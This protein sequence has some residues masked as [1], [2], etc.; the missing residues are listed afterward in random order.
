MTRTTQPMRIN[1]LGIQTTDQPRSGAKSGN[2]RNEPPKIISTVIATSSEIN[3]EVDSEN[4]RRLGFLLCSR[5]SSSSAV[6]DYIRYNKVPLIVLDSNI[7]DVP[8]HDLIY[9]IRKLLKAEYSQIVV[10]SDQA[11]ENFVLDAV[12]AGCTGFVLRPYTFETLS[13][14]VRH[15]PDVDEISLDEQQLAQAQASLSTGQFNEAIQNFEELVENADRENRDEAREYFDLGAKCLLEKKFGKAIIAFNNTLRINQ[16]YIKAY[17]GLAG[18]FKGKGDLEK[19]QLYL[20]KAADEYARMDNFAQVKRIF[21]EI[22]KRDIHAPNPYNTLGIELRH[23]KMFNE[24]ISAYQNALKL[25]PVDENIFFN[26]AKAH[27]F[28]RNY[29]QSLESLKQA[30][31]LNADHTESAALYTKMTGKTWEEDPRGS[32]LDKY[33]LSDASESQHNE[34]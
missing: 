33:L 28:A 14:H 29:E 23:K 10:I 26:L 18:A 8:L 24:A 4:V 25:S 21:G 31:K 30:L 15:K 20:Q 13:K 17:E 22:L 2:P 3:F 6:L 9:A 32:L 11:D 5:F 1:R 12:M 27:L 7:D 34:T 16:L 19:Y